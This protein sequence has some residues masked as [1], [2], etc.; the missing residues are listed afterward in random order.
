V[1]CS[2]H[3]AD[4]DAQEEPPPPPA[5]AAAKRVNVGGKLRKASVV[6]E[7]TARAATTLFNREPIDV[8]AAGAS[9]HARRAGA[10]LST[11]RSRRPAAAHARGGGVRSCVIRAC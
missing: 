3:V 6:E 4:M 9:A 5:A 7:A 8:R 10:P 1:L 2:A 11:L